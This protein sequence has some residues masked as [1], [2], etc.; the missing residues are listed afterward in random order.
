MVLKYKGIIVC[1][2]RRYFCFCSS[3]DRDIY[4]H[5]TQSGLEHHS[6]S[7]E[8]SYD[9]CLNL[10]TLLIFINWLGHLL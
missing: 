1:V 2:K 7:S 6:Y 8:N 10:Y 4:S 3:Y 5:V 9:L